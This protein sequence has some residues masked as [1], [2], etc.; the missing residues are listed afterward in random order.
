MRLRPAA[1]YVWKSDDPGSL[2]PRKLTDFLVLDPGYLT[3][4]NEEVS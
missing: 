1:E 4:P 3:V 2:E